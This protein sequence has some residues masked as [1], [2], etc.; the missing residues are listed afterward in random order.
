MTRKAFIRLAWFC[1][2]F[3]GGLGAQASE[4][5][6]CPSTIEVSQKASNPPPGWDVSSD[7]SEAI[8][9]VSGI[10]FYIGPPSELASSHPSDQKT[11]GK[12][13]IL[14]WKL[15]NKRSSGLGLWIECGYTHTN[16]VLSKRIP[17]SIKECSVFY[18]KNSRVENG[19]V[20]EKYRV[21]VAHSIMT[22]SLYET[23]VA[24]SIG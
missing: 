19:Y 24:R 8:P 18:D 5:L 3:S 16:L 4:E 22:N 21:Q 12:K 2:L 7:S 10:T 11:V 17:D 6:S 23:G 14:T 1:A 9:K 13:L 20:F 15:Y